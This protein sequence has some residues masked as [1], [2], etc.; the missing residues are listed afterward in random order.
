MNMSTIIASVVCAPIGLVIF[1]FIDN[2]YKKIE[3]Q[4]MVISIQRRKIK[5]LQTS[6]QTYG[7]YK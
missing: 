5:D 1:W 6:L 4:D 7:V 3:R 2:L